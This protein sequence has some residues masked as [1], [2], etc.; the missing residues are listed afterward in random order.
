MSFPTLSRRL[1][2]LAFCLIAILPFASRIHFVPLPQWVWRD[3]CGVADAGFRC[4]PATGGNLFERVPR[5]SWWCLLLALLWAVQPQLVQALF[6]GMTHATALAWLAV[7]LLA[8]LAY[9]L[10]QTFGS[11]TLPSGWP[12]R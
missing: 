12:A 6:P 7:A 8:G 10:Q 2:L 1:A 11:V 5:A 3:E 4:V 9:S